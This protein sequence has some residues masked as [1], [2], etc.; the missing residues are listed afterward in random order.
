MLRSVEAVFYSC[1][2]SFYNG[3]FVLTTILSIYQRMCRVPRGFTCVWAPVLS[4][5]SLQPSHGLVPV[6][7][8]WRHISRV[9]KWQM[10][11]ISLAFMSSSASLMSRPWICQLPG[12]C[13]LVRAASRI[14]FIRHLCLSVPECNSLPFLFEYSSSVSETRT[15][16]YHFDSYIV[17]YSEVSRQIR[18]HHFCTTV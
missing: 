15:V 3:W 7:V 12:S 1:K 18:H 10:L 5:M 6:Y 2:V 16:H 17:P 4:S 11:T 8:T 14:P 13:P 9:N